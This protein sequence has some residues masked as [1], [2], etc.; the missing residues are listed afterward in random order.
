MEMSDGV[1]CVGIVM[2]AKLVAIACYATLG[3]NEMLLV[4]GSLGDRPELS[5]CFA[6]TPECRGFTPRRVRHM[7]APKRTLNTSLQRLDFDSLYDWSDEKI[8]SGERST[9]STSISFPAPTTIPLS[10]G[11]S[12]ANGMQRPSDFALMVT[13][14]TSAPVPI[15]GGP[16]K[17]AVAVLLATAEH[18]KAKQ[19]IPS[20]DED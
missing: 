8:V 18:V 4:I 1:G 13:S 5:P 9:Q 11:S 17:R 2:A 19:A 12:A 10:R 16:W 7:N 6:E 14:T 3:S 15:G 20:L